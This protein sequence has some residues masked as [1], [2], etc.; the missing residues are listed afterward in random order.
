MKKY[1][2]ATLLG[3]GFAAFV[4]LFLC[5]IWAAPFVIARVSLSVCVVA[6]FAALVVLI[7]IPDKDWL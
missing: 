1:L 6:L 3:I 7:S 2:A 4:A 5:V